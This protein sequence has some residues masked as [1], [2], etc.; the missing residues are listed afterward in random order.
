MNFKNLAPNT[1]KTGFLSILVRSVNQRQ[2]ADFGVEILIKLHL[3]ALGGE[4]GQNFK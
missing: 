3:V 4:R 2:K 1:E